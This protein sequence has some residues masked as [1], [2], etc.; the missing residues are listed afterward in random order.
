M[1]EQFD[2]LTISLEPTYPDQALPWVLA[3]I[4]LRTNGTRLFV[5]FVV[6]GESVSPK[7]FSIESIPG[8]DRL[9]DL[10]GAKATPVLIIDDPNLQSKTRVRALVEE[11]NKRLDVKVIVIAK[12]HGAPILV[13]NFSK[14]FGAETFTVADFSL[15]ALSN[16]VSN[17]FDIELS[18]AAVLAKKINDTFE[19]FNMHAHPS[20]FAG[21]SAEVLAG[22]IAANRR[23]ELI[24]LAVD[25][26][27]MILVAADEADVHVSKSWR[28]EFL[29]EIVIRQFIRGQD[30]LEEQAVELAKEMASRRDIDIKPLEFVQSF[31]SAGI[32]R[33]DRGAV[34]FNLVYV[35]DYLIAEYLNQNPEVARVY[36]DFDKVDSDLMSWTSTLSWGQTRT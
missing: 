7:R 2:R 27:L 31:V 34:E 9:L 21:I 36:F 16:F 28:R 11:A 26:A 17:N 5:P 18:Q 22:I 24:Q 3:D 32:I 25:G 4:V 29:M 12:R 30:V 10:K 13:E 19:Q 1:I 15:G 23:G 8:I 35:R 33:F 20:Y 14:E 6:D